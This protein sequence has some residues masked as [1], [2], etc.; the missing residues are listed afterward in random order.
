[1]GPPRGR[2]L[3]PVVIDAPKPRLHSIQRSTRPFRQAH[4]H[5]TGID[6]KLEFE[7]F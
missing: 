3:P 1:M 6:V 4:L 5:R 7:T 2:C